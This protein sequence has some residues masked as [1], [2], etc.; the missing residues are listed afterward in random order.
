MKKILF[1]ILILMLAIVTSH[2]QTNVYHLFP[3]SAVWRVDYYY[4]NPFQFPCYARYYFQYYADGDTLINTSVYKK[5][6]RSHVQVDT[7]SCTP[8]FNPPEAPVSGYV[9]ALKDDQLANKAFFIFPDSNTDSL[10][11][12]YNLTT[13]DTLK[14]IPVSYFFLSNPNLVVASTDSIL[15]NGQFRKRWNFGLTGH[16]AYPYIIEGIGSSVGLIEPVYSYAFDFTDR[17]LVCVKDNSE[18]YYMSDYNSM[19]GCELITNGTSGINLTDK[20][21]LFPNPFSSVTNFQFR[22]NV[23]NAGLSIFNAFGQQVRQL[24]G[25]NGLEFTFFRDELPAGIYFL[26]V[27]QQNKILASGKFVIVE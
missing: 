22:N 12:D 5:I 4:N 25:I 14:G 20:L 16:D 27:F 23:T 8:P 21:S 7:L 9:G 3:D 15:I 2:A 24:E 13:G 6:Y 11:Y 1:T 18:T 19:V 17:Y 10:L 26:Q